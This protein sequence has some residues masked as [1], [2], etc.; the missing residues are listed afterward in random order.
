[1][2][3]VSLLKEHLNTKDELYP[4]GHRVDAEVAM[5]HRMVEQAFALALGMSEHA[6]ENGRDIADL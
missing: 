1:M 3:D 2:Q 4:D 6:R 5:Y